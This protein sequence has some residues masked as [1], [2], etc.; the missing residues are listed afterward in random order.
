MSTSAS[1][2]AST[3]S[4][5]LAS[6]S[7]GKP[8]DLGK[9]ETYQ[10]LVEAVAKSVKEQAGEGSGPMDTLAK[11]R[12]ERRMAKKESADKAKELKA[13]TK[14]VNRLQK[15]AA[16]LSDDGLLVEFARRQAAKE[17]KRQFASLD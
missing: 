8:L 12:E 14:R 1:S 13:Y 2:S 11:L 6:R 15:R 7:K 16:E 5:K 4:K 3:P 17:R 9:D 10:Y